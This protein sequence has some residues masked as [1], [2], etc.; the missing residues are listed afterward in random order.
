[1]MK[2]P[3][4]VQ[5]QSEDNSPSPSSSA[6][7][8]FQKKQARKISKTVFQEKTS[9]LDHTSEESLLRTSRLW[10]FFNLLSISFVF[11][12]V[13]SQSRQFILEGTLVGMGLLKVMLGRNDL[14]L[15]WLMLIFISFLS[16]PFQKFYIYFK[17][18]SDV[19]MIA[20]HVL[21]ISTLLVFSFITIF[22]RN[23]PA[24]QTAFFLSETC[25]LALKIHSYVITNR[26]FHKKWELELRE[27]SKEHQ[28]KLQNKNKI[29]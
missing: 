14:F 3:L 18:K 2:Q 24:V 23:W 10:G 19:L 16:V 28:S 25:V 7:P 17:I 27:K 22:D 5:E 13:V 1:M 12:F 8:T 9:L 21:V 20:M 29:F 15:A 4:L 26:E 11:F 6:T